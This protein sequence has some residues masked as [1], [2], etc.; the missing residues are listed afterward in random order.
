MTAE[1]VPPWQRPIRIPERVPLR[2]AEPA[3]ALAGAT[4]TWR[5]HFELSDAV[6]AGAPLK[7]QLFGGRNNKP[8]FTSPQADR[9]DAPG[10]LTAEAGGRP[11]AVRAD[12]RAGTF[13]LG[14]PDAGLPAGARLTVTLG[15]RTGGGPG[16]EARHVRTLDKFSVLYRPEHAEPR[17]EDDAENLS[18]AMDAFYF[19]KTWTEANG[20]Q[21]VGACSM[22]VLGGPLH[23]LRAYAPAQAM[24]GEP[25]DVL[26]RPEDRFSNLSCY[27]LGGLTV[28]LG[29][30]E[31]G[32]ERE[33][34]PDSTCVRLRVRLPAEGVHRLRVRAD[35]GQEAETSPTVCRAEAPERRVLWGMIH[36]HTEMS[37]GQGSLDRY[38]RQIRDEAALDFAA[39]GDHDHLYET[40]DAFWQL[41]CEAVKRWHEPGRFVTF[42][43]Y[44][45]AKWRR[46][47][48][49]DRNVYY[50]ADDR[51]L[52][53]SDF[54]HHPWPPDL[55]AAL[56]D[57]TALVIPHHTAHAGSFCDWTDHDPL[58]ERLVEI[59]Q[60]RGSYETA[61]ADNPLPEHDGARPQV[62]AGMVRRALAMGWRVGFT[63]GGDDH[64]GHAG[65]DFPI[66]ARGY[67]AGLLSV[68]ADE[69]TREAIWDALWNRRVVASSGPRIL[70]TWTLNGQPMGSELDAAAMPELADRRT[71]HVEFHGTAPI[72]RIDIIRSNQVIHSIP[73]DGPDL[74]MTWDDESPLDDCLLPAAEHCDHPFCF[75]YVRVIQSDGEAAWASPI[76]L[77][78]AP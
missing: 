64:I 19:P 67:K 15:D 1:V 26:V 61:A 5:L 63:A 45:W 69:C 39:P 55:F 49:G 17:A 60:I 41:T 8:A 40:S 3:F 72:E 44:E 75:Y 9:P 77:D 33:P 65:T 68:L 73:G 21:I 6:P 62:F 53:R 51:P 48:E 25:V 11:L 31:I 30:R 28:S 50:L 59:H 2:R 57:E 52:Y 76:W 66:G 16:I 12:G 24:P 27:P 34:V 4:G 32:A 47:G 56:G 42:L 58:H 74:A 18:A 38:F 35:A 36:G 54:G 37:D 14:V 20:H 46:K 29:G 70:L 7:L 78:P 71:L 22:H 10:Y 23:H 43:G 13:V